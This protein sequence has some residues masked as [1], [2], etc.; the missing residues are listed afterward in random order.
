M[1]PRAID[2]SKLSTDALRELM[3]VKDETPEPDDG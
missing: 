2:A 3:G 1:A